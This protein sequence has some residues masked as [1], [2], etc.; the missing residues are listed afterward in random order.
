MSTLD[1]IRRTSGHPA[2]TARRGRESP[3]SSK[4]PQA[5][6]PAQA[7]EPPVRAT[8]PQLS[9][10]KRSLTLVAPSGFLA[11]AILRLV[12]RDGAR[13]IYAVWLVVGRHE[14]QALA[15]RYKFNGEDAVRCDIPEGNF[16][17]AARL[18]PYL[19]RFLKNE[20][21]LDPDPPTIKR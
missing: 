19:K 11:S 5:V 4:A 7:A 6:K 17:S 1:V 10:V 9:R 21:K 15:V 13:R 2:R 16:L 18:E 3:R 20:G 8:T 12:T 14:D